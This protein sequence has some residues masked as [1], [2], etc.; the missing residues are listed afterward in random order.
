MEQ[1]KLIRVLED[2]LAMARKRIHYGRQLDQFMVPEQMA[3]VKVVVM[4]RWRGG[5]FGSSHERELTAIA[6]PGKHGPRR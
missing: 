5:R 1:V 3:L 2:F 4:H 6:T